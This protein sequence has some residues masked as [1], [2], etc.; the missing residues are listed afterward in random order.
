MMDAALI[1]ALSEKMGRTVTQLFQRFTAPELV[2]HNL[3]H[4]QQVVARAAEIAAHCALTEDEQFTLNAA[5]WWHDT[6]HLFSP[7]QN[8]EEESA[9]IMESFFSLRQGTP[10]HTVEAIGRA[11]RA[12]K[13]PQSPHSLVE[14]I[15]CDADTYHLGTD[16]FEKMNELVLQEAMMRSGASRENWNVTTLKLMDAHTFHTAYC[17]QLLTA[18]KARNMSRLKADVSGE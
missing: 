4:T 16:E 15:L 9:R 2:Y 7:P 11:I 17:R 6:G 12:T 13:L 3:A 1:S 5:A 10:Q 18:G 8:H 14:E